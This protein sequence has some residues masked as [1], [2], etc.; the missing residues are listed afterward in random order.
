MP[1]NEEMTAFEIWEAQ[2][3]NGLMVSE[4]VYW[5][6]YYHLS[7]HSYEWNNGVLE[8]RP[9]STFGTGKMYQWFLILLLK[10]F[11]AYPIG[12]P[13]TLGMGFRLA[14]PAKSEPESKNQLASKIIIRKPDLGVVL[15]D[16]PVPLL[17][18]DSRYNGIFDICVEAI[19]DL[20][21]ETIERDTVHKKEEYER[22]GVREYYIL[23]YTGKA[24]AFYR[25]N[26]SGKYEEIEPIDG[27][28]IQSEVLPGF[29][30]RISD[31]HK[32]PFYDQRI[33]DRVY[34]F[35]FPYS[36]VKETKQE[37]LETERQTQEERQAKE[38]A[39]QR[40]EN[41]RQEKE[42]LLAKLKE[43]GISLD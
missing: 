9:V 14:F 20:T 39:L 35:V 25:L 16:N 31:L 23:D 22:L 34:D 19:G 28:I 40:A 2:S 36:E 3:E 10:Y 26:Q 18:T 30:F 43:L 42:R 17:L 27:D 1:I 15:D 4:K 41:E 12:K 38:E 13:T 37:T 21:Q 5:E 11:R 32:Q 29:G 33:E 6:E 24:M 7:D 8:E